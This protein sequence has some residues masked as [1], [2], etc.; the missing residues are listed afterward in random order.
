MTP[1]TELEFE[2]QVADAIKQLDY[3]VTLEPWGR[4]DQAT[5]LDRISSWFSK[6]SGSP[7]VPDM[8]VA[9][10]RRF[11]VVEAKAYPVLLGPVIQA[12]HYADYFEAPAIICVPDD[13]FPKI[14]ESVCE[15]AELNGVV[16]T[17]IAEIGE[18]LQTLLH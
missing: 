10:G 1:V 4:P 3:K 6:P 11:A 17:P 13:A 18:K 15:L 9:H 8:M 14:P 2:R 12:R 16:L 5:W 7:F